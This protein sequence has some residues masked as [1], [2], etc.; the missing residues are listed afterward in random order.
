MD[1]N[2]LMLLLS[3]NMTATD[4]SQK[5]NCS[6][7][8]VIYW[9]KKHD[10]KTSRQQS[11]NNNYLTKKCPKCNI[12]KNKTEFLLLKNNK[13]SPYCKSCKKSLYKDKRQQ[14]KEQIVNLKGKKCQNCGYDNCL[15]ALDLH[16]INPTEKE[17]SFNKSGLVL[18]DKII[19]ELDKCI[20]LCSNCHREIHNN[21]LKI[22]EILNKE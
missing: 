3:E 6:R 5:L 7:N 20:L 1:K 9:L 21:Y 12:V 2:I 14:F 13:L 22:E 19:K 4:I 10:L 17:I 11:F 15:A 16:H 18:T 8:K